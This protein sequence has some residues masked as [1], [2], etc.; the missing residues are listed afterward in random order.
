M[1]AN[2]AREFVRAQLAR[3]IDDEDGEVRGRDRVQLHSLRYAIALTA[4]NE[5]YRYTYRSP[6]G[7]D[8]IG[9]LGRVHRSE[10][11]IQ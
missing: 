10:S 3:V 2:A 7:R 5:A 4:H 11:T 9:H 8:I 6:Y 1:G